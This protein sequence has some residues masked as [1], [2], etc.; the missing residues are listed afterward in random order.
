MA[1][2]TPVSASSISSRRSSRR[3]SSRSSRSRSSSSSSSSSSSTRTRSPGLFDGV[4]LRRRVP[5]T[6]ANY[7]KTPGGVT[8]HTAAL[9]CFLSAGEGY[10][11]GE[12]TDPVL[13]PRASYPDPS[14]SR[15]AASCVCGMGFRGD[16]DLDGQD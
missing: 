6:S 15:G 7:N 14:W 13:P 10:G 3:S 1:G 12:P 16:S 5:T 11:E 9:F 8:L 4:E 2:N